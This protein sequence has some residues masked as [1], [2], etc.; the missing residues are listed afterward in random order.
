MDGDQYLTQTQATLSLKALLPSLLQIS[1][2]PLIKQ[3]SALTGESSQVTPK[4][5]SLLSMGTLFIGTVVFR[6][7]SLWISTLQLQTLLSSQVAF[8]LVQLTP[9]RLLPTTIMEQDPSL[10]HSSSLLQMFLQ[11]FQVW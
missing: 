4:Q 9:S 3:A 5:D 11:L 2:E 7:T 8:S 6:T 10:L 1:S